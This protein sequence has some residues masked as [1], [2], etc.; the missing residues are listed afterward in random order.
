MYGRE[1]GATCAKIFTGGS[2]AACCSI[3]HTLQIAFSGTP[4][5]QKCWMSCTE[6]DRNTWLASLIFSVHGGPD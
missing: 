4:I 1:L 2:Y 6:R 5:N 3:H